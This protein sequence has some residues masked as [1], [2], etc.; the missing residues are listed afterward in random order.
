MAETG[1]VKFFNTDKGFGFIKP[2]NGGADIFVHISAVQASGLN[3][4]TE[5]QKVSYDTEPDRRGKGP[6][7]VNL[8]VSG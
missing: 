4:L 1:I 6:K 8:N 7:A 2:D 3:D 5:N